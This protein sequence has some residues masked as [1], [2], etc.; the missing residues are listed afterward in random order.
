MYY[1]IVSNLS[2]LSSNNIPPKNPRQPPPLHIVMI[3]QI[4]GTIKHPWWD[5]LMQITL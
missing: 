5:Q 1:E 4:G 2:H 3:P